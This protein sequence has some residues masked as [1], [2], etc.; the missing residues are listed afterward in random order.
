MGLTVTNH[1]P[2]GARLGGKLQAN[3][4]I[5]YQNKDVSR[6]INDDGVPDTLGGVC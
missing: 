5:D 3:V 4:V 2:S 6:L 1:Q